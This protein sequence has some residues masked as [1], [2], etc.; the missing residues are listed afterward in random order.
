MWDLRHIPGPLAVHTEVVNY[1]GF[2]LN[3]LSG[4]ISRD[5]EGESTYIYPNRSSVYIVSRQIALKL[6]FYLPEYLIVHLCFVQLC[7]VHLG[8]C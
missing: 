3:Y 7:C 2:F 6:H 5:P 4:N 1:R 8:L